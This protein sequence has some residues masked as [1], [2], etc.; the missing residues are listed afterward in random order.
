MQK[1]QHD[2]PG[3]LAGL[4]VLELGST[5]AGPF[6]GRLFADF[7]AA[8]AVAS[9]RALSAREFSLCRILRNGGIGRADTRGHRRK[10]IS[11][12]H[13]AE[14]FEASASSCISVAARCVGA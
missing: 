4:R 7:G 11:R 13:L 1:P 5:V 6:C 10:L 12:A 14:R 8:S 9:L 2:T 3:P